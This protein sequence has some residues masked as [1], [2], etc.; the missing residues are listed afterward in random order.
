MSESELHVKENNRHLFLDMT[1][2]SL[3]CAGDLRRQGAIC[4]A[5]TCVNPVKCGRFLF[6]SSLC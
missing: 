2:M 4:G 5:C 1:F 3:L 6:F